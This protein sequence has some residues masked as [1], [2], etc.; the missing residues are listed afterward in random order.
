MKFTKI[1]FL[2][3]FV[4]LQYLMVEIKHKTLIE[5]NKESQ[6]DQLYETL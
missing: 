5:R 3:T 6:T 1:K 4:D 2:R